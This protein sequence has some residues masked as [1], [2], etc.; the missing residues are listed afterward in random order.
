VINFCSDVG[1]PYTLADINLANITDEE[2]MEV[3]TRATDPSEFI[4]CYA[5]PVTAEMVFNSIKVADA[6][7]MAFKEQNMNKNRLRKE[8]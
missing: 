1:L 8:I 6:I 5:F 2:L 4:H 7:G 3:A